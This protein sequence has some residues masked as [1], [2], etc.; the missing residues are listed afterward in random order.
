M[1]GDFIGG[2][3]AP[4]F[5]PGVKDVPVETTLRGNFFSHTLYWNFPSPRPTA[6][7]PPPWLAALRRALRIV[8]EPAPAISPHASDSLSSLKASEGTITPMSAHAKRPPEFV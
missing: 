4:A 8:Q 1:W 7:S 2:P 5:G 3:I 6:D